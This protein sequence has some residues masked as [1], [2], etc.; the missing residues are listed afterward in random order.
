MEKRTEARR[1]RHLD[2]G[3]LHGAALNCGPCAHRTTLPHT[4]PRPLLLRVHALR[5]EALVAGL[6]LRGTR[7]ILHCE[8]A[9][10]GGGDA[11]EG[12]RS[13]GACGCA[14]LKGAREHLRQRGGG[15]E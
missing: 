13:L 7:M 10:H 5:V 9:A 12:A 8:D 2:S 4:T 1:L 15:A 6:E 11:G 3:E 14:V